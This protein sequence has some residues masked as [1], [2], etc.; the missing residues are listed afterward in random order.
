MQEND[1]TEFTRIKNFLETIYKKKLEDIFQ[2]IDPEPLGIASLAQ[3]HK[4]ILKDGTPVAVKV[5]HDYISKQ[6][7]GDIMMVKL[8]CA[9]AEIIFPDFKY[10][11]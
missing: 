1:K 8:G 6:F 3:V 2:T 5:Q 9:L 11:V 4:A 10:K 7:K